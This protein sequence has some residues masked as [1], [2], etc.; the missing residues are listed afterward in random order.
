MRAA[1]FRGVD[2]RGA[3]LRAGAEPAACGRGLSRDY[4]LE[5]TGRGEGR[6]RPPGASALGR[7]DGPVGEMPC[8]HGLAD[9]DRQRHRPID[10]FDGRERAECSVEGE[11]IGGGTETR[12]T[13]GTRTEIFSACWTNLEAS[14]REATLSANLG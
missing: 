5:L 7:G 14:R 11:L 6:A 10:Q 3:D 4:S 13:M 2:L 8:D 9:A 12:P 1:V